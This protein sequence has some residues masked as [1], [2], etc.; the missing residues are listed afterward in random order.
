MEKEENKK[1]LYIEDD[2]CISGHLE[3]LASMG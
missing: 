2:E 1:I 3:L